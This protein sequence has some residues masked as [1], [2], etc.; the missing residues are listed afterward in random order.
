MKHIAIIILLLTGIAFAE[1]SWIG[2]HKSALV[3]TWGPPHQ[4]TADGKG[5]TIFVYIEHEGRIETYT[6]P[7]IYDSNVGGYVNQPQKTVDNRHTITNL[8]Y[9]NGN[10]IIYYHRYMTN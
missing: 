2:H 8:F 5:G 9:I 4:V 7:P 6:P 10:G 1:S 3:K